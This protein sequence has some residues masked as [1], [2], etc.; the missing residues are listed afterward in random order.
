MRVLL[1]QIE[2]TKQYETRHNNTIIR[3]EHENQINNRY[4]R[5]D[6]HKNKIATQNKQ[7]EQVK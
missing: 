3:Y 7:K 2:N 1:R 6:K 5:Q 4:N